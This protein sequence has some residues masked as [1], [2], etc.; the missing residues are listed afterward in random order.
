MCNLAVCA[1]CH[2]LEDSTSTDSF[3]GHCVDSDALFSGAIPPPAECSILQR[4]LTAMACPLSTFGIVETLPEL[5]DTGR[6]MSLL[7]QMMLTL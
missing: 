1:G 6:S 3:H 5:D 2:V 4:A 7:S